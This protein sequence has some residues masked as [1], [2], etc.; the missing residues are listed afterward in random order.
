MYRSHGE[1]NDADEVAVLK[2]IPEIRNKIK[3]YALNDTWNADEFGL[4]F[5]MAPTT[6]IGLG[7]LPGRKVQ[8]D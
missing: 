2:S 7:Q 6:T 8:K 1:K 3:G 4:F 5:K